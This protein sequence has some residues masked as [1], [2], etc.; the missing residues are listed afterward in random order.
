ME[1][2]FLKKDVATW[3]QVQNWKGKMCAWMSIRLVTTKLCDSHSCSV[4]IYVCQWYPMGKKIKYICYVLYVDNPKCSITC[5]D[6]YTDTSHPFLEPTPLCSCFCFRTF[7]RTIYEVSHGTFGI[8][9]DIFID[10]YDPK[11]IDLLFKDSPIK[12]PLLFS[13][14]GELWPESFSLWHLMMM[15]GAL[16]QTPF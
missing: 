15:G 9:Y 4:E 5:L 8:S 2:S 10:S 1:S 6:T 12:I 16:T 3:L 11:L 14:V 13:C 7:L